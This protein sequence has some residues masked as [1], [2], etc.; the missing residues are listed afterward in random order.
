M[1]PFVWHLRDENMMGMEKRWA[2]A[3][4]EGWWEEARELWRV[5]REPSEETALCWIIVG[6]TQSWVR[7]NH[8]DMQACVTG[9]VPI[10]PVGCGF[11][12]IDGVL[13]VCKMLSLGKARGGAHRVLYFL[14]GTFCTSIVISK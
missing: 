7:G 4:D 6:T 10:G 1:I 9:E 12:S 13:Q 3:R 8:R 5:P 2:V 11:P 14:F